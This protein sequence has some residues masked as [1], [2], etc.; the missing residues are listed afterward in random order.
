MNNFHGRRVCYLGHVESAD[1]CVQIAD[2]YL[3]LIGTYYVVVAG[4]VGDKFIIIFRG[5]GY[6]QDCGAIAQKAFGFIGKGGGHR[7]A[8]RMEVPLETL[9]E[10]SGGDL[11]QRNI[12]TFLLQSLKRDQKTDFAGH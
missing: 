4:I 3:R 11:D 12:E 10:I 8:A 9:K 6:R 2:F 1:V 7:S 5:D